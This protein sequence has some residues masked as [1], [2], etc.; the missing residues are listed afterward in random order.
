[1]LQL[2]D[3]VRAPLGS[4]E[5]LWGEQHRQ[6]WKGKAHKEVVVR[7]N[8]NMERKKHKMTEKANMGRMRRRDFLF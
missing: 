4:C 7:N 5:E 2:A 3:A 1:M 8:G 6:P